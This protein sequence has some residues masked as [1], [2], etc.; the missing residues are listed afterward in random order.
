MEQGASLARDHRALELRRQQGFPRRLLL[1][2]ARAAADRMGVGPDRSH[3]VCGARRLHDAMLHYNHADRRQDGGRDAAGRGQPGT[4][5]D[6]L[7][8]YGLRVARITYKW[9][10][11]DKALI[12]HALDQMQMSMEAIGASDI[13]RQEDDTNHLGGTARMGDRPGDQRRGR[14]LPQLGTSPISG[15]ATV[16]CSRPSAASTRL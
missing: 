10:E 3:G 1:D 16:R 14:R 13:F 9:G 7:D 12:A 11:N 8:Q 5:A 4:L 2:G 6:D 15:S